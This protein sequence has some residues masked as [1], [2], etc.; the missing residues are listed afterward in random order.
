MH[1]YRYAYKYIK[2]EYGYESVGFMD[3]AV[4]C[5]SLLADPEQRP[6]SIN[7]MERA[8][9]EQRDK[10]IIFIPYHQMLVPS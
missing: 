3:P 10:K 7:Y 2:D 9:K 8:L 6:W 5:Y 1:N 4:T